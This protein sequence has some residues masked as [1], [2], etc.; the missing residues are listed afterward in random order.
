VLKNDSQVSTRR[1]SGSRVRDTAIEEYTVFAVENDGDKEFEK[2]I[3]R[4]EVVEQFAACSY[5]F[6]ETI[7]PTHGH[8]KPFGCMDMQ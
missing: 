3:K 6:L 7:G 5:F 8:G 1:L 4:G 2:V